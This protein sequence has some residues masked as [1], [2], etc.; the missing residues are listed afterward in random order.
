[1]TLFDDE[2][3]IALLPAV[4]A[5]LKAA[6]L[7]ELEEVFTTHPELLDPVADEILAHFM[8]VNVLDGGDPLMTGTGSRLRLLRQVRKSGLENALVEL[9]STVAGDQS[10]ELR[11]LW[12]A[13]V[14]A[15]NHDD[16]TALED[17]C[18]AWA[19]LL[20]HPDLPAASIE[21]QLLA[22][23][24]AIGEQMRVV[25]AAPPRSRELAA[26]LSALAKLYRDRY[27]GLRR[28]VDLDAG[29]EAYE[30]AVAA[31]PPDSGALPELLNELG[32]GLRTRFETDR[33]LEDLDASIEAYG[34]AGALAP[35]RSALLAQILNDRGLALQARYAIHARRDD[36]DAMIDQFDRAVEAS[37]AASSILADASNNLGGVLQ[38]RYEQDH[39]L[40]DLDDSI[41]AIE[42]AV[43]LT[44]ADTALLDGRLCN[45][46]NVLWER[47]KRTGQDQTLDACI[48]AQSRAV[49]TTPSDSAQIAHRL[50]D[51]GF[52]LQARH[53][54]T[55]RDPDDLDRAIA[56]FRDALDATVPDSPYLPGALNNLSKG[57]VRRYEI[58]GRVEDLDEALDTAK[59]AVQASPPSAPNRAKS[60]S[61]V[62]ACLGLRYDQTGDP[63]DLEEAIATMKEAAATATDPRVQAGAYNNLGGNLMRRFYRDRRLTDLESMIEA[64]SHTVDLTSAASPDSELPNALRNLGSARLMR[65]H[66]TG[67]LADL[68]AA[69]QNYQQC[70]E[71]ATDPL[72]QSGALSDLGAALLERYP[73]SGRSED[74]HRAVDTLNRAVETTPVGAPSRSRHL[75]Q[76]ADGLMYRF[77]YQ[78]ARADLDLAI[79][80]YQQ[81][82][83]GVP[84][85]GAQR[86]HLLTS[87][88][89]GL[90]SRHGVAGQSDDLEAAIMALRSGCA[91][92]VTTAPY[93]ALRTAEMW[94]GSAAERGAWH[95][96]AEAYDSALHAA[97]LLVELQVGRAD[98][99]WRL[100]AAREL[101]GSAAYALA[102]DDQ[103]ET[104]LLVLERWRAILLSSALDLDHEEHERLLAKHPDL[105]E[106]YQAHAVA[107]QELEQRALDNLATTTSTPA[108]DPATM[109]EQ[110][111]RTLDEI[112]ALEGFEEFLLPPRFAE[113]ADIASDAPIAYLTAA[114]QGGVA[115][116]LWPRGTITPVWLPELTEA[117]VAR[118]AWT[119]LR[120]QGVPG[121]TGEIDELTHWLWSAAM[122]P[123]LAAAPAASA[124][125]LVPAGLLAFLPLHAAWSHDPTTITGRRYALDQARLTY[126]GNA[127]IL[128][129]CREVARGVEPRSVLAVGDPIGLQHTR[130]ELDAVCAQFAS[131]TRL[132]GA[133]VDDVLA[134]LGEHSVLHFACHGAADPVDPLSSS[135]LVASDQRLMLQEVL[136]RRLAAARLVVLS[137][138]ETAVPSADLPNEL[139]GMPSSFIEAGA[140]AAIG[141]LWEVPD[142]STMMLMA[143][144]YELWRGQDMEPAEAL[145]QA[146]RWVRDSTNGVKLR[147]FPEVPALAGDTLP[148]WARPSWEQGHN[149]AAPLHW[150]AFAYFGA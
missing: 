94:G 128:A 84:D 92:A 73:H 119:Y 86:V 13:A 82:L 105:Y 126:T 58:S 3:H 62:G 70:D 26:R 93:T 109:Q 85:R 45:L 57:L 110:Q 89:M 75:G 83:D 122:G 8:M 20:S 149:H 144:F 79:D 27:S 135:L 50:G 59:R 51:L 66:H 95:E 24:A 38:M 41:C 132:E 6:G 7:A 19:V 28:P 143:Q 60:L 137:A 71:S 108:L 17:A 16:S 12:E 10:Q 81:A 90:L 142:V 101:P 138:C 36:L 54:R 67:E 136:T 40:Q 56:A 140:G 53:E 77:L 47:F 100:R 96:A 125:V 117:Q 114:P 115:L 123:L 25:D 23:E 91:L 97:E 121:W 61:N 33:R 133:T 145:R 113:I 39:R 30:R 1:M 52:L 14:A 46:T 44:P 4:E 72:T 111:R 76:Q 120:A 68:D 147:R 124:I 32:G 37:P 127:R 48:D 22:M 64:Y 130:A 102:R 116:V 112:R 87:L 65:Y 98:K 9:P 88:G 18:A 29:I 21:F 63:H 139:V 2:R 31:S 107:L 43:A 74:L 49:E 80:A 131:V 5:L 106:R 148:D 34:R 150:A 42:R 118:R 11:A 55:S 141:S 134:A 15:G 78:N 129:A 69:I 99:Q 103:L 35:P 146:Q 104:A